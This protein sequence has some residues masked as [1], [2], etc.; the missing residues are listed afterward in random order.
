M[1]IRKYN[2]NV[3]N[4]SRTTSSN[5]I[6]AL[7]FQR[8]FTTVWLSILV[9]RKQGLLHSV[10]KLGGTPIFHFKTASQPYSKVKKEESK[11]RVV[12]YSQL[13]CCVSLWIFITC[14]ALWKAF[15]ENDWCT[16]VLIKWHSRAPHNCGKS[17][18]PLVILC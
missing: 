8:H 14:S 7:N 4:A 16:W 13:M 5:R 10:T 6:S 2:K 18:S 11:C 15:F 17:D 12:V 3:Y 1:V 9:L